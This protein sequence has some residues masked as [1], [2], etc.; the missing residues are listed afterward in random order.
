MCQSLGPTAVDKELLRI[1]NKTQP[2]ALGA[3]SDG[4]PSGR[5][6]SY[7]LPL[8]VSLWLLNPSRP[9]PALGS[10]VLMLST[11]DAHRCAGLVMGRALMVQGGPVAGGGLG[12]HLTPSQPSCFTF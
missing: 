6:G 3:F 2:S 1:A 5:S 12:V 4:A 10:I 7:Y 8:C 9:H 11:V